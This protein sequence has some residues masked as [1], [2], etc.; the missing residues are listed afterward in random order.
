M[1]TSSPNGETL[2]FGVPRK[3]AWEDTALTF[4]DDCGLRIRR[5]SDR[6]LLASMPSMPGVTVLLQRSEDVLRQVIDGKIDVGI[7][8]LDQLYDTRGEGDEYV[9]LHDALGFSTGDVVVAVPTSWVDVSTIADL[10]EVALTLRER[11]EQ[12]RVATVFP[13]LVKRFFYDCGIT[14]FT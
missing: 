13:N 12:L 1:A 14:H 5:G 4:L 10:G 8:G 6:Q 11:G 9:M 2:R 7:T 3:G